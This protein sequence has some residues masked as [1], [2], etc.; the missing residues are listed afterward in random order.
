MKI[1]V[2]MP[3]Y[4]KTI[5]MCLLIAALLVSPLSGLSAALEGEEEKKENSAELMT[6]DLIAARPVGL[7]ATVGGALV[8]LVSWPFS[9]LGGNSDTAWQTLV[10]SPAE[11]TFKRPLGEFEGLGDD[12]GE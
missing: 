12:F 9:A 7:V 2:A 10:V 1:K 3:G 8:F 5:L 6:V 4:R 11:Y